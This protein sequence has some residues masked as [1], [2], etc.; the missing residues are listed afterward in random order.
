[1]NSVTR[2][3]WAT[4]SPST[5][6]RRTSLQS[7]AALRTGS[8]L[9]ETSLQPDDIDGIQTI[10]GV[11]DNAE[12]IYAM[13]SDQANLRVLEG[14]QAPGFT[15]NG[16]AL[17]N[18]IDATNGAE[19]INGGE[20]NDTL[21]GR[22]GDDLLDGGA[23][24][25]RLNGQAGID[26]MRGG[27]GDD[28]YF[29]NHVLDRV[30]ENPGDGHDRVITRVSLDLGVNGQQVEFLRLFGDAE[31]DGTGNA[32]ANLVLGND[33][34]N[35]L[36]GGAGDDTLRG[37]LGDDIYVV[38]SV[39]DIAR[40]LDGQG[41]DPVLSAV[42]FNLATNG[43]FVEA[44]HLIGDA[45]LEG[46]GSGDDNLIAGNSG[47]NRLRGLSGNDTMIGEGGDDTLNAGT[48]DDSL[49]G[50]VGNDIL[51]GIDG[52]DTLNGGAGND[53]LFGGTDNERD[54]FLFEDGFGLDLIR[55]FDIGEDVI[56]LAGVSWIEDFA[57]MELNHLTQSGN[58]ARI[59]NGTDEIVLYETLAADLSAGDFVFLA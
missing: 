56:D 36:D 4:R 24:N 16:N 7:A 18:R 28:I 48:G 2:L 54:V 5:A 41:M 53:K 52:A 58:H 26:T 12:A 22:G 55:D 37:G 34:N 40:E 6:A 15:V 33:R 39:N 46:I 50:G 25:D 9:S 32:L 30:E 51:L 17:N 21:I 38:D 3:V 44:L 19:T 1:M 59:T 35:T 14:P 11:Q 47:A 8:T 42:S 27:E 43:R 31:I 10:Y 13:R 57:D 29:V 45:D 20:G 49:S 23:G